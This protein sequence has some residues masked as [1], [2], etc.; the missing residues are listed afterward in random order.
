MIVKHFAYCSKICNADGNEPSKKAIKRSLVRAVKNLG[1]EPKNA[2]TW[3]KTVPFLT[4]KQSTDIWQ[5]L[6]P[7]NVPPENF[8]EMI[9]KIMQKL[10]CDQYLEKDQ[11]FLEECKQRTEWKQLREEAENREAEKEK[12]NKL[13]LFHLGRQA[14]RRIKA[15]VPLNDRVKEPCPNFK[16]PTADELV[17][18]FPDVIEV[19]PFQPGRITFA[20]GPSKAIIEFGRFLRLH[21]AQAAWHRRLVQENTFAALGWVTLVTLVTFTF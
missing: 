6:W 13:F 10:K 16:I 3:R 4:P 5:K 17:T 19:E 1:C 8:T 18:L 20:T 7:K 12:E 21:E 15:E 2:C 14:L 9:D 11:T